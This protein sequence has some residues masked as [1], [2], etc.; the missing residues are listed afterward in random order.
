MSRA[1][2]TQGFNDY[3]FVWEK[4]RLRYYVN[5]ELVQESDRPRQAAEPTPERSSSA[6]G[7][8]TR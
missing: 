7:A 6:C 3:A 8:P 2:P 4:D 1:A 5:G